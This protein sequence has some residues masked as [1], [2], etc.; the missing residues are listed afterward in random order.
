MEHSVEF[1]ILRHI[2]KCVELP[3]ALSRS[4]SPTGCAALREGFQRAVSVGGLTVDSSAK[5]AADVRDF[6]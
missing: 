6:E 3:V 2:P 5:W 1:Q 4:Y